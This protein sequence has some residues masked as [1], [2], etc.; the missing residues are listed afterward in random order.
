MRKKVG[1]GVL[2]ATFLWT[3]CLFVPAQA[4]PLAVGD[5]IKFE[6]IYGRSSGYIGGPYTATVN[7]ASFVTFCVEL[8]ETLTFGTAYAIGGIGNT[9]VATGKS[10][11][12]EVKYLYYNYRTGK[13]D[14]LFPAFTYGDSKDERT[15]QG[16]IWKWMGWVVPSSQ[17]EFFDSTLFG[18]LTGDEV[19]GKGEG[20]DNVVILNILDRSKSDRQDVLAMVPEPATFLLLGL[21]LFGFSA[22]GRRKIRR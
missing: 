18:F 11:S 16:A 12:S 14:D 17:S 2:V 9:T 22:L 3:F 6:D 19:K 21:G 1:W 5:G 13:L 10:L 8:D 7:G 20:I 15:L 4:T